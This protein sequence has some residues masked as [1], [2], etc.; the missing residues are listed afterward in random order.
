MWWSDWMPLV[1]LDV[2]IGQRYKVFWCMYFLVSEVC[3]GES[4]R[5]GSECHKI[6]ESVDGGWLDGRQ[7][8]V[9]M[10]GDLLII[11][12]PAKQQ[13]IANLLTNNNANNSY[14]IGDLPLFLLTVNINSSLFME[15]Y[16]ELL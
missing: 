16:P 14:W 6:K 10:G 13:F 9:N 1:R 3:P 7:A 8:C 12:S 11:D 5:F 2:S 15:C 4:V